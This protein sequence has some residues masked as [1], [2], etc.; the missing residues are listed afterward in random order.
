MNT[1]SA[2]LDLSLQ[3]KELL[4]ELYTLYAKPL[5]RYTKRCYQIN[6]EDSLDLVY[7]TIYKIAGISN[8]ISF[9][10]EAKRR[11]Y[12]F[13]THI[14]FLRNYFRD[15]KNFEYKNTEVNLHDDLVTNEAEEK[16]TS[17]PKLKLLESLLSE[18]EDW[19][20]ILLLMRGQ[21]VSYKEISKL[22]DKPEKH[23]KVYYARLKKQLLLDMNKKLSAN[24]HE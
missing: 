7:K 20:R 12:V 11:A 10:N 24:N 5:L 2:Q 19:Q 14:N 18:L 22:T 9:E 8:A 13:K 3:S 23:L 21:G 6:E 17:N 1:V 4:K 15:N 16:I